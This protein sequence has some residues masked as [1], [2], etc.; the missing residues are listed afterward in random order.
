MNNNQKLNTTNKLREEN[1]KMKNLTNQDFKN[2]K[3]KL[4]YEHMANGKNILVK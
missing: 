4:N 2:I 1:E 3:G